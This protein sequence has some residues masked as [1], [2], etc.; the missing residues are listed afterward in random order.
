VV[1]TDD[2]EFESATLASCTRSRTIVYWFLLCGS[3]IGAR[4]TTA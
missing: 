2:G 4:C 3:H 1:S